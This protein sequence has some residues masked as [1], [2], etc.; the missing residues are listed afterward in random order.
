M[1]LPIASNL[2][3]EGDV[4]GIAFC[5]AVASQGAEVIGVAANDTA[6]VQ[7]VAGDVTSQTWSFNFSYRII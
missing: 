2:G 6:K 4:S 7:W 5:G 3:A 1:T